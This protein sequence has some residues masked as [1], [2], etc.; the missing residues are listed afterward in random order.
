MYVQN[1]SRN[2]WRKEQLEDLNTDVNIMI[3][4]DLW[5]LSHDTL[6]W[7]FYILLTVH[8]GTIHFNNQFEALF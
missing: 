8:L 1:I 4:R 7:I 5:V 6:D 3:K 2:S